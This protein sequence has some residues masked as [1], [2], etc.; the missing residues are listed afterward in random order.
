MTDPRDN[1]SAISSLLNSVLSSPKLKKAAGVF[2][3]AFIGAI[4]VNGFTGNGITNAFK[5][6]AQE[7]MK[8]VKG[9]AGAPAALPGQNP[10]ATGSTSGL[11]DSTVN[12]GAQEVQGQVVKVADGD[13]I[14]TKE[15]LEKIDLTQHDENIKTF[16]D[17]DPQ[18]ISFVFNL[19]FLGTLIPTQVFARDMA[20]KENTCIVMISSM[21]AYRPLTKIPA[22]SAA[23]A[24]VSNFTQF[25]AVHFADVGIR[26][27]AIAPGFFSTN[28]NKALLWNEDGTPTARTGKILAATPMKRFGEPNELDGT[29][30]FLC[31]EDYSGFITGTT[32]PVDGG[33]NAYSGV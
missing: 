11:P 32:I 14:T 12:A 8:S 6:A 29:L 1:H 33:F 31:D 28:Q 10:T 3:A 2:V 5:H 4:A 24:A 25:M 26:V 9:G 16:F 17:L 7:T 13:T 20:Q 23:K 18:G 22:Y 19:N 27:N 30:L 15:T 21:N